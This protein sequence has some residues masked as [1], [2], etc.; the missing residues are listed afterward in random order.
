MAHPEKQ[1]LDLV[2]TVISKG[3]VKTDRTGVGTVS[4]FGP[5]I[6]FDLKDGFPLV[7]TKKVFWK[8]VVHELLWFLKGDTNIKYLND[9]GVS[10]W[11]SWS[12]ENG[13]LGPVYGK[14]WRAAMETVLINDGEKTIVGMR[15]HD[16]IANMIIALRL[17]PDSRRMVVDSWNVAELDKMAL[18][19]CHCLFQFYSEPI[20]FGERTELFYQTYP[21]ERFSSF[22][23]M[24]ANPVEG[25][26]DFLDRK[27]IPARNLSLKL[28]QRSADL[29]LG[30][31]F[32]IASYALLLQ[33]VAHITNHVPRRFIHSFGDAHVY[34]N[35]VDKLKE[36]LTRRPKK[37]P[38]V[39]LNPDVK[40]ID[41]FTFEDITLVDYKHHSAIK[42][43]IAV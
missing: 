17:N 26:G 5:Q 38:T 34:L 8:G 25:W 14:Q 27:K 31:P 42:L 28:Y 41:N 32:N 15:P 18:T 37:L 4:M 36:Q 23:S 30:V 21:D 22:P 1:Y 16:Q 43:D 19:P 3:R 24:F 12:D 40:E 35:H 29:G 7:T 2:R 6:E 39:T 13:D 10:I 20:E 11:D 9:N 33:M